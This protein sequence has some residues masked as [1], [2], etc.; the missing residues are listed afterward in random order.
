MPPKPTRGEYI[1]T[2]TGNKV[3]RRAYI[4]GTQNIILGGKTIIQSE[5]TIRG[6]LH[7]TAPSSSSSSSSSTATGG[8]T[9]AQQLSSS[10]SS[11]SNRH[12]PQPTPQQNVAVSIGRYCILSSGCVLR[13]PCKT[14]RGVTSYWPLKVGDHVFVGEGAV[15][16]AASIGNHVRIGAGAVIGRFVII[17]D[18]VRVVDGCVVPAGMVIPPFS[19]VAGQPGQVVAELPEGELDTLDLRELYRSI[20]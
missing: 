10:S 9:Q 6:D 4:Q 7:R 1:E 2:E 11:S 16:E 5:C 12:P 3:S 13:P 14:H 18:G 19:I 8:D 15:I 17:K 20:G